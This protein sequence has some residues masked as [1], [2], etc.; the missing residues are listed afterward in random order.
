M[1][2]NHKILRLDDYKIWIMA[3][4]NIGAL[5]GHDSLEVFDIQQDAGVSV[6]TRYTLRLY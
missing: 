2:A 1:S 4:G 5:I 6:L 3:I